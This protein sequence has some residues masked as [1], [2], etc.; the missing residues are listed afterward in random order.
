MSRLK[1]LRLISSPETS[2]SGNG[3]AIAKK[4]GS[5]V[6]VPNQLNRSEF[7]NGLDALLQV[8]K[9]GHFSKLH[10]PDHRTHAP[11]MASLVSQTSGHDSEVQT[12]L[13]WT[14]AGEGPGSRGAIRC[15]CVGRRMTHTDPL[16]PLLRQWLLCAPPKRPPQAP[17]WE[18]GSSPLLHMGLI[19]GPEDDFTSETFCG[20][21]STVCWPDPFPFCS[22]LSSTALLR[23][24]LSGGATGPSSF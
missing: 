7:G 5:A 16:C 9:Q 10:K 22:E 18:P 19:M 1:P 17:W 4:T 6:P 15:R 24:L 20:R 2:Q 3:R 23:L 12:R 14:S 11:R 13:P 21:V 8:Q